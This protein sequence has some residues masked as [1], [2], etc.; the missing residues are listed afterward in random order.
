MLT[1]LLG[2]DWTTNSDAVLKLV[3]E[4]VRAQRPRRILL[5]PELISHDTERR[6]CEFAGDSCSRFAEVVSFTRLTRRICDWS[7]YAMDE[8]LDNGGRLVAMAAASRQLHSRIKAYAAME[9][10]PEFLSALVDAVDEFKRCCITSEDLILAS[11]SA[12]GAFAQKLEEL[13]LLLETYDAVCEHGKRDPRDQL[14]WGLE[15]LQDSDFAQ[16]HVFYIDG[17]PDFTQQNMAVIAY[18]IAHSPQVVISLNCDAPGSKK[19]AFEKAGDTTSNILKIARQ[20]QVPYEI[21]VIEP[22]ASAQFEICSGLFQGKLHDTPEI[23]NCLQVFQADSIYEECVFAAE[24]ILSLVHNGARFRDI[25]VVCPDLSAYGSSLTLQLEMCGIPSYIAGTDDILEKSVI[26][27]VLTALDTALD[28]FESRDVLRYL[29]SALSPL[30]IDICDK[31]ENY[32]IQWGIDGS[33]WLAP[34]T[35]HPRGLETEW[36]QADTDL[37]NCLNEARCLALQPL[38]ELAT[39]F[40]E[41]TCLAQQIE[42]LSRY[43]DRIH[44]AERLSSLAAE[45]DTLGDNRN[46]QILNQ[47]WDIL[48][49][50]LEQLFDVLGQTAWD[51]HAF[52]RLLKLLLSQYDVGTIPPVLDTVHIGAVSAMRCR[53]AKHLIVIGA[54]E[55]VFP[56]YASVSGVLSDQERTALRQMGVPLTGGASEGLQIEFSE[57]YGIFCGAQESIMVTCP[58]GQS[59]FV[60]RRLATMAGGESE[61]SNLLGAS[62][63]NGDDAAAYLI[64]HNA[65]NSASTLR[66][67]GNY[68]K[69]REKTNHSLGAITPKNI[70][71]LYGSKFNL[72]ASQVDKQADCRLAYFFKYGLR[73]QERKPV[74]VDPAEFGTYVHAVLE[75]TARKICDL[76]GFKTVTLQQT[77][78]IAKEYSDRYTKDHFSQL[79]SE[80]ITYLFQRNIQELMLIVE[81]LWSELQNSEFQPVAFELAFGDGMALPAIQIPS[82]R[83]PAQLRGFVDR[84]DSWQDQGRNYYRVVDYKTGKKD[85]DY[86]DI[87]NGLGL[88]MLLYLFALEHAEHPQ[89]GSDPKPAGVQYF[90]ARV[91]ILSADGA[92]NDEEATQV[93]LSQWKRKGLILNDDDVLTAMEN[94]ENP[95]RLSCKRRKDGTVTGDIASREQFKL[96]SRYV[97]HLLSKM[98]DDIA[99]GNVEPNPYTRGSSH[100]ACMFCPY[101]MICHA[102]TVEGRRNYQAMSASRF[103]DDVEKEMHAHG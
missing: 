93:R 84:V 23:R 44:M 42:S 96:L 46:A 88:Q 60:F 20:T 82:E 31:I 72:S 5:V 43:L 45:M 80:R 63:V 32:A 16:S 87:F 68:T 78:D 94:T 34:W 4:D 61:I 35:A 52:T 95:V 1:L 97:L 73:A 18:L 75:Q 15:L 98:V 11:K 39:G 92:L 56:K 57:I 48:L 77:L 33:K 103:W 37:L 14:S 89:L 27:T 9:T 17:F 90:P 83:M 51:S 40:R 59:S 24:Q 38:Q 2:K 69:I 58:S 29:K 55:G 41:A 47:L 64:R 71:R 101:S 6:L 19:L 49:D 28:G 13:S 65:E 7:G 67:A 91:P 8:C 76:G 3:S 50:A 70:E 79:D 86:C 74:S 85:F 102:A 22:R 66:I 10:K 25:S 36:T 26:L 81:E 30:D 62:G 21:R 100:N 99:S 53:Q 12:S 54:T